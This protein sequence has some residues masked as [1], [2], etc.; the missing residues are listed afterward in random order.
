MNLVEDGNNWRQLRRKRAALAAQK[1]AANKI[2][3]SRLLIRDGRAIVFNAQE[4]LDYWDLRADIQIRRREMAGMG[5]EEARTMHVAAQ[6]TLKE[7]LARALG[8]MTLRHRSTVKPKRCLLWREYRW[9]ISEVPGGGGRAP[10][11]RHAPLDRV[12]E[13][14]VD[15]DADV[16]TSTR[17]LRHQRLRLP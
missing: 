14:R 6:R 10:G 2:Q 17:G 1:H 11:R 7:T 8:L 15:A 3:E 9:R 13:G 16:S 12:G 4:A 5:A